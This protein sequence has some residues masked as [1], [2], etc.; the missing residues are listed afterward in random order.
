MGED[1][2]RYRNLKSA[3][4][5]G[6]FYFRQRD[7]TQLPVGSLFYARIGLLLD[8]SFRWHLAMFILV[9]SVVGYCTVD[10]A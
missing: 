2:V 10:S 7:S 4:F 5:L 8:V 6:L 3:N 1:I 9:L